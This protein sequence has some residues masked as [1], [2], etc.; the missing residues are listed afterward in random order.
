MQGGHVGL[1]RIKTFTIQG[2]FEH[3]GVGGETEG[4]EQEAERFSV[5]IHKWSSMWESYMTI[6]ETPDFCA[7]VS[8]FVSWDSNSTELQR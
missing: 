2:I 8:P 7:S 5:W 6:D 3:L 1:L 4:K